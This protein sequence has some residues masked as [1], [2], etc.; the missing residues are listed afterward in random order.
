MFVFYYSVIFYT[1]PHHSYFPETGDHLGQLTDE[2]HEFGENS[3]I[4]EFVSA[5][6]KQV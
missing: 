1:Q 4:S 3:Y 5:G 2:L 6:P